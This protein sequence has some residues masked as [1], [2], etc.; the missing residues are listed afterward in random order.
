MCVIPWGNGPNSFPAYQPAFVDAD[1]PA[2]TTIQGPNGYYMAIGGPQYAFVDKYENIY[3]SSDL[4]GFGGSPDNYQL[5][6]YNRQGREI[7][8]FER[9]KFMID[10]TVI[11]ID[12]DFFVDS[13]LRI[14]FFSTNNLGFDEYDGI[15]S[16]DFSGIEF[17]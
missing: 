3:I 14:F 5:R 4:Y 17:S 10:T 8:R 15:Y 2:D 7:T 13:K 11:P 1:A 16:V 9:N 6:K 12:H